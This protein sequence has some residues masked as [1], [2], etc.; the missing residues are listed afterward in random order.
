LRAREQ[1]RQKT[2][3]PQRFS[4]LRGRALTRCRDFEIRTKQSSRKSEKIG[5]FILRLDR[6][7]KNM[8]DDLVAFEFANKQSIGAVFLKFSTNF[9]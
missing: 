7:E 9:A 6:A 8:L 3:F 5:F 2:R 4:D 1:K